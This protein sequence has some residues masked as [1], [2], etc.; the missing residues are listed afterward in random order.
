MEAT[1]R[2]SFRKEWSFSLIRSM[3]LMKRFLIISLSILFLS[4][5]AG[6]AQLDSAARAALDGRLAEYFDALKHESIAVQKGE[7]DFLI[8]SCSDSLVRQYVALRIYDHYLESPVMGAEAVAIHVLDNWF[9]PG[10]VRMKSD[11]DLL[12]ARVFADFNR[13]SQIGEKAPELAV[14]TIGGSSVSLFDEASGR[15]S[16]LYFYDTSCSKC[17]L[18]S[19]LLKNLFSTEDFPVDIYAF[20]AGDD[21]Q[22]WEAYVAEKLILEPQETDVWSV[23]HVWDPE[24]D[25]DFQRKYGVLQTPRLFLIGPDGTILG[26]GLDT[27]ALAQMLHGIFD[28]K[29]L[30]YGS[31]E[32]IAL[33]DGIFAESEG[34]PTK[35]EVVKVTDHIAEVTLAKG[36]TVMFRQMAGDL[37]YYL[38]PATGEGF[39]EGLGYLVDEYIL[40]RPDIWRTSD[41]SLK[42]VGFAGIMY[43]LLSKAAPGTLLP[44]L[45]LPGVL[46]TVRMS[47][48]RSKAGEYRPRKMNGRR[49]ILIFYT[50]G[51][52][53][54]KAEKAAALRLLESASPCSMKVL[55]VNVDD[56]ISGHPELAS[57]LFESFDLTTLPY[58][59]E[60]DR[61]G[62]V[63]RRYIT[64]L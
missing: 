18:E 60:A 63:L 50:D 39:K 43:D 3:I 62:R 44:D 64:I 12:N 45:K 32:S 57:S 54:C 24:L 31:D 36:D 13:L 14:K 22:A 51:C 2:S 30:D 11:I 61:S 47:G 41:D 49:N 4:F 42:V 10:K 53:I 16:V 5:T 15:F 7:C 46:Q 27:E 8:E 28:E 37:L 21:R 33:Y 52:E 56:V 55:L 19:I 20:Y 25:S 17:R 58:I 29:E 34:I 48:V 6:A 35:E 1:L 59:L 23:R 26:R 40:S 9:F 38:A